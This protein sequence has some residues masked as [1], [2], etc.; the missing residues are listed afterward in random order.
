MPE[1]SVGDHIPI[2]GLKVVVVASGWEWSI[3]AY[4]A[5]PNPLCPRPRFVGYAPAVHTV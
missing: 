4:D 3:A 5:A 2:P 1:F